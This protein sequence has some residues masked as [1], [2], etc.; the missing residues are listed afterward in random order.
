MAQ[1]SQGW[2]LA[3]RL[4]EGEFQRRKARDAA[5]VVTLTVTVAAEVLK[6]TEAG[7]SEQEALEGA[8]VQLRLT[9]PLSP[10]WGATLKV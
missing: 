6:L 1:K 3:G 5:A 9:V 4:P 8:P 2:G 7:E 10:S